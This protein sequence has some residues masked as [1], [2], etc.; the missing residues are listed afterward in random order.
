MKTITVRIDYDPNTKTYGTTSEELPDIY[1]ISDDRD[2]VLRRFIGSANEYV[3]CLRVHG[4]PLPTTLEVHPEV[5]T[6]AI[7]VA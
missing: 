1:A 6:V 7:E 5:V 2:D 3:E 4:D